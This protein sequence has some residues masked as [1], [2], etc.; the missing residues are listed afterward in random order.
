MTTIETSE[1]VLVVLSSQPL[2]TQSGEHMRIFFQGSII[3][4]CPREIEVVVREKEFSHFGS[5]RTELSPP[6]CVFLFFV[7]KKKKKKKKS[8]VLSLNSSP[9]RQ[10]QLFVCVGE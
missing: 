2:P 8:Y 4:L 3:L 7:K 5:E 1:V 9:F 6:W 10:I